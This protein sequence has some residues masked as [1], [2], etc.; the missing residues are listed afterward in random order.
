MSNLLLQL[1]FK[2]GILVQILWVLYL[3]VLGQYISEECRNKETYIHAYDDRNFWDNV[4]PEWKCKKCGKTTND[5]IEEG[6][7]KDGETERIQTKYADYE[8]V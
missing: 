7:I 6:K 4:V 1:G 5:L 3:V 2:L 8:V